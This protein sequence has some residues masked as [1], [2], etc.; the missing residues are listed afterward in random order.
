MANFR[1]II[2]IYEKL[3]QSKLMGTYSV[4]FKIGALAR[5]ISGKLIQSSILEFWG[6]TQT[7]YWKTYP[8]Q[9]ILSK[10]VIE[11]IPGHDTDRFL[12]NWSKYGWIFQESVWLI[13]RFFTKTE[14]LIK[15]LWIRSPEIGLCP[16]KLKFRKKLWMSFPGFANKQKFLE[17][18]WV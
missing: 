18:S 14:V 17:K 6:M 4:L 7:G 16:L 9:S 5:P 1:G 10:N 2:W 8:K 11:R 12:E 3:I 15:F 13:P